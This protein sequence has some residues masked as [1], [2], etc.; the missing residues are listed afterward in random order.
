[1]RW[2]LSNFVCF[3]FFFSTPCPSAEMA[4]II[5]YTAARTT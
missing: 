5:F 1:L 4:I 2:A 3:F